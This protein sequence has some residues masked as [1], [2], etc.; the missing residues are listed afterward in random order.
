VIL[1]EIRCLAVRDLPD[2]LALV[3][4]DRGDATPS[5]MRRRGA[6]ITRGLGS[7]IVA[8]GRGTS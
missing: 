1:D 3:E 8:L 7:A 5:V 6:W 2:E 4:I